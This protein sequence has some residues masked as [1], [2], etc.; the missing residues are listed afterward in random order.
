MTRPFHVHA[1]PI[2]AL[3]NPSF[4]WRRVFACLKLALA[5]TAL[6]IWFVALRP[7]SL[8]GP[9]EY[10]MVA[11]T[12]MLPTLKTGDVVVARPQKTYE[13]GDIVAYTVPKGMPAAGGRII[14]R[15]IGGS[16][17]RGYVVKG[18]NRQSADL[19]RPKDA[20]VIGKAWIRLPHAVRFAQLMRSPLVLASLAAGVVFA[21]LLGTG[22]EEQKHRRT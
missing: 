20:D 12:S 10:V 11:G 5:V 6:A 3:L 18:D 8:G 15:I 17:T 21:C 19:W 14:H 22:R 1:P 7:Q 4:P 2:A 9:A 13:V 16:G